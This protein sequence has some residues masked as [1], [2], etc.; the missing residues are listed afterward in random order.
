[1][2][3]VGTAE[4]AG[5]NLA[6]KRLHPN[7]CKVHS[8]N[9][10]PRPNVR[11]CARWDWA[12]AHAPVAPASRYL[13]WTLLSSPGDA[14]RLKSGLIEP[15]RTRSR[16]A[17]HR[18]QRIRPRSTG[19]GRRLLMRLRGKVKHPANPSRRVRQ[20]KAVRFAARM[21]LHHIDFATHCLSN[22]LP[23]VLERNLFSA[24][25]L[26]RALIHARRLNQLD[27]GASR[28][29]KHDSG[30]SGS[31]RRQTCRTSADERSTCRALQLPPGQLCSVPNMFPAAY[32]PAPNEKAPP[33][34]GGAH[35]L[36]A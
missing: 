8:E 36:G 24:C 33:L 34:L 3:A 26:F 22:G 9:P 4:D 13:H 30:S 15:V 10:F 20:T 27:D 1:V 19:H 28:T 14:S 5:T 31:R 25:H 2:A 18:A 16:P 29:Q 7:S 6:A 11:F 23:L 35:R 21:P 17:T 12:R 32:L